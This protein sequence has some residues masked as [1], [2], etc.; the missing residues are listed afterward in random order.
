MTIRSAG[1]GRGRR[2][3]V[4][5]TVAAAGALAV[6]LGGCG[7]DEGGG[8]GAGKTSAPSAANLSPAQKVAAAAD[9]TK[10]KSTAKFDMKMDMTVLGTAVKMSGEGQMDSAKQAVTMTMSSKPPGGKTVKMKMIGIGDTVYM[11]VTGK[12]QWV[13]LDTSKASQLGVDQSNSDPTA[14]LDML[15]QVSDD[16]KEAG[17]ETVNGVETTKYTGTIDLDKAA[18][19][20]GEAGAK[21][22]DSYKELGLLDM[23]FELYIDDD[24]M[25]SRMI[26]KASGESSTEGLKGEIKFTMTVNYTDWGKPVTIKAPKNAVSADEAGLPGFTS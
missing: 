11:Q 12:K 17:R 26:M 21:A 7:T 5:G 6:L 1:T 15:K 20:E 18:A 24:G 25:P 10:E 13:K 4:S 9:V 23:P 19:A 16:V 8:S 14:Q 2:R 22:S 3:L